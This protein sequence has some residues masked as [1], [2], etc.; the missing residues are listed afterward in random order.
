MWRRRAPRHQPPTTGAQPALERSGAAVA[1]DHVAQWVRFADTKATILA[2]G[3]GVVLSVLAA[4]ADGTASTIDG[5][6][7]GAVLVLVLVAL[8]AGALV[9]TLVYVVRAIRPQTTE[10]DSMNRFAWPSL[11]S[12]T[13]KDLQQHV[14]T[15]P[16]P[17]AWRQVH[18]LAGV[19]RSK[20]AACN[21]A[22]TW[23]ALLVITSFLCISAASVVDATDHDEQPRHRRQHQRAATSPSP[24]PS[25]T[26]STT[27][28]SSVSPTAG[29]TATVD[30]AGRPSTASTPSSR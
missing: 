28:T 29:S 17:E 8:T 27:S 16:E 11:A 15:D 21:A 23:F 22:V 26:T 2:A 10:P 13:V 9:M 4:S 14:A 5:G 12:T 30:G 24:S 25:T 1:L 7:L 3:L 18:A 19:A 20:Y 6:G